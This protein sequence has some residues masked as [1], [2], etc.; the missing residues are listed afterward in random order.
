HSANRSKF[1]SFSLREYRDVAAVQE[2]FTHAIADSQVRAR[3]QNQ[4]MARFQTMGG[5]VVSANYFQT[6][7]GGMAL[8]RPILP[9]DALPSA[10]PVA[11][12]GH[13]SWQRTFNGDPA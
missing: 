4:T 7:G 9:E 6:L 2:V 12:L 5:Y 13:A 1:G 10:P 11:V 8:G 3:F